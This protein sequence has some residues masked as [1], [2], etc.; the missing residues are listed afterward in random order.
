MRL[1]LTLARPSGA[2]DDIIVT[3]DAGA[4]I[5]EV[6]STIARVD[7]AQAVAPGG[8]YTLQA[9]LPGHT[10]WLALPPDAPIGE[11]WI[12]SGATVH[13]SDAGRY[14]SQAKTGHA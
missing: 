11:A 13:L 2:R 8:N 14:F 3:T 12:G 10:E 4:T 6:A 9:A 7:P 1:K 5:T